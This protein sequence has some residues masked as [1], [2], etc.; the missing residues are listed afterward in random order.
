MKMHR[1]EIP[2]EHITFREGNIH[3]HKWEGVLPSAQWPKFSV[4]FKES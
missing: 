1:T 4:L 2:S 3:K